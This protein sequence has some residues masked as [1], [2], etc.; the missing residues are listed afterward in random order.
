MSDAFECTID[1]GEGRETKITSLHDEDN[2]N[3]LMVVMMQIYCGNAVAGI[4]FPAEMA[5]PI[6]HA[7]QNC[8]GYHR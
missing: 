8:V 1:H 5:D 4:A 3:K 7:I 6:I 2:G